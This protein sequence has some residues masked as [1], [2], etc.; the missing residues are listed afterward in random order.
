MAGINK[1]AW[2]SKLIRN[3][4]P[5][6]TFTPYLKDYS[7]DASG[8]NKINVP[9]QGA[10]RGVEKNFNFGAGNIDFQPRTDTNVQISLDYYAAKGHLFREHELRDLSYDKQMDLAKQQR[11]DIQKAYLES[12]LF[13]LAPSTKATQVIRTT[14][15]GAAGAKKLVE[16]DMF[17]LRAKFASK[18][19]PFEDR[20]LVINDTHASHIAEFNPY[21]ADRIFDFKKG[22]V[23]GTVY[24][25][26]IIYFWGKFPGYDKDSSDKKANYT[27]DGNSIVSVAFT[28]QYTYKALGT[29]KVIEEVSA[30]KHGTLLT[31]GVY[32]AGGSTMTETHNFAIVS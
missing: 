26:N 29:Y 24:G 12:S 9:K 15:A 20:Y 7:S 28:G 8:V 4:V 31:A 14:G 5:K 10:G 18:Q 3:I 27:A 32:M 17:A 30:A 11:E 22:Q 25:F 23:L 16:S 6:D 19:V 1:E 13:D 21:L 2:S